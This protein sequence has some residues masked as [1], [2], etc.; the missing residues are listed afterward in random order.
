MTVDLGAALQHAAARAPIPHLSTVE[1]GR[2]VARR[3]AAR[4]VARG[5]AGVGLTGALALTA[6][7]SPDLLGRTPAGYAPATGLPADQVATALPGPDPDAAAGACG[8]TVRAPSSAPAWD[9]GVAIDAD[10]ETR[11]SAVPFSV[12]VQSASP[13]APPGAVRTVV[14]RDGVVVAVAFDS[15][16][17]ADWP[18][19]PVNGAS[20]GHL[21]LATCGGPDARLT[22]PDGSY[23]VH[24]VMADDATGD[25]AA[26]SPG[27]PLD[28]VGSTRA[29][30]CGADASV[31]PRGDDRAQLTALAG[32]G[33]RAVDLT[34]TWHGSQ[35]AMLLDQRVAVVDDATGRVVADSGTWSSSRSSMTTTLAP[36]RTADVPAGWNG[37][38]CDG[39]PLP[40]GTYRLQAFVTLAPVGAV[41]V[42]RNVVGTARVDE[43]VV[44]P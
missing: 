7:Q 37:T 33:G 23:A 30:W 36:G 5:A 1:L 27:E 40:A 13:T 15:W 11:L 25:V 12:T 43:A 16:D 29:P 34:L 4:T 9:L 10:P 31:L 6:T 8:W 21:S 35:D 41:G 22:L 3:R 20:G 38:T 26:L 2:R 19:L 18:S 44:V 14:A 42:V 28:V 39:T 24:A 17:L 32:P